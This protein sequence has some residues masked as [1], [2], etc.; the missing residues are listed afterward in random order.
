MLDTSGA[1]ADVIRLEPIYDETVADTPHWIPVDLNDG[2]YATGMG[3]LGG[4]STLAWGPDIGTVSTSEL[5]LPPGTDALPVFGAI[6]EQGVAAGSLVS[7]TEPA[8][9]PFLVDL[10]DGVVAPLEPGTWTSALVEDLN[11]GQTVVG[12]VYSGDGVVTNMQGAAWIGP[13]HDLVVVDDLGS[14]SMLTD[15]NGSDLAAGWALDGAGVVHPAVWDLADG[16]AMVDL[17]PLTGHPV[18]WGLPVKVNELGDVLVQL[19]VDHQSTASSWGHDVVVEHGT[20]RVVEPY[21]VDEGGG[22]ILNNRGQVASLTYASPGRTDPQYEILDL[23][24]GHRQVVPAFGES[25]FRFNDRGQVGATRLGASGL[26]SGVVLWDPVRGWIDLGD[27]GGRG[28]TLWSMNSVGQ[29]AGVFSDRGSPW[30][31][32]VQFGPEPPQG[33]VG[34]VVGSSATIS[35][36]APTSPGNAA[37]DT[38]RVYRDGIAV[39]DVAARTS[40]FTEAVLADPGASSTYTVTAI[41]AFGESLPSAGA[42]VVAPAPAVAAPGFV[43]TVAAVPVVAPPTFTG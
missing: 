4:Y 25:L 8:S 9:P 17:A 16:G 43:P 39:A 22:A 20:Q 36:G 14:G 21:P 10:H 13:D 40:S 29:V 32:T 28:T 34:S 1:G 2:G 19:G 31:A 5:S 3:G 38:Y 24:T 27:G 15:V 6:N 37:I 23:A 41:N 12:A 42:V 7:R 30:I 18:M 11:A 33:V 35:W 26:P